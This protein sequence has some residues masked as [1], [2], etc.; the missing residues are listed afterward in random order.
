VIHAV[1]AVMASLQLLDFF[2]RYQG[3]PHQMAAI[4]QLQ[5]SIPAE[6]LADDAEW[7]V[8]WKASGRS[9]LLVVP[10][11]NQ[12]DNRSRQGF[13]ECFSSAMAMIAA[14][15]GMV[16]T[17]DEYNRMRGW[18]GDTTSI[19]AQTNTLRHL[20]L[21]ASFVNFGSPKI[22]EEEI[23]MGHPVGV[24]LL[25]KGDLTKG[26]APRG[27]GHWVVVIGYTKEFYFLHDPNG[28]PDFDRG[29]HV[30]ATGGESVKVARATLDN[31]WMIEGYG[32]GW[33]ITVGG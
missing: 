21:D 28:T 24:G 11:F 12:R 14:Y 4:Q 8:A 20:G 6:V 23:N 13:R 1:W 2:E 9:E 30:A 32:S 22:I 19:A 7:F 31:R 29:L 17:D 3:T 5:E 25:F 33:M 16:H 26:E 10:Y 27:Y 15:W 18:F